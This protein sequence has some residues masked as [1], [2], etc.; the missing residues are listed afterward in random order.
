MFDLGWQQ[1]FTHGRDLFGSTLF[2]VRRICFLS[3]PNSH[4]PCRNV[5]T[6]CS[7][8]SPVSVLP[9]LNSSPNCTIISANVRPNGVPVIQC[10]IGAA[11]SYDPTLS[12]WITL[13]E[14]WWSEGSD[15]WQGRQRGNNQSSGRGVLGCIESAIGTNGDVSA[16]EKLRPP[17][18]DAAMT[19]GHLETRLHSTKVLDSPQEYKQALLLYAKKI[20]DEAFKGK[21]EELIKEL[22]GPIYWCA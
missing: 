18:W 11:Y 9:L 22:Y 7:V 6:Q 1:R 3:D 5:K 19:L 4:G 8:F 12:T 13:S 20:S 21:A 16:A 17:W 15:A 2:L 14:R 10:S